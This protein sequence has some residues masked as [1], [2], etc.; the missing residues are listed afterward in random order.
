MLTAAKSKLCFDPH[1][2]WPGNA[3]TGDCLPGQFCILYFSQRPVEMCDP[4]FL[5]FTP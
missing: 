5:R 1:Q 4:V 2:V 3:D